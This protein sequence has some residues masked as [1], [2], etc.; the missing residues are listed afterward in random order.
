LGRAL[1]LAHEPAAAVLVLERRLQIANQ[2]SV[3][4]SELALAR[5]AAAP[6]ASATATNG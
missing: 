3:V 1:L 2:Q 6:R 5:T 4:Q